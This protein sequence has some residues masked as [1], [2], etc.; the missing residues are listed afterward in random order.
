LIVSNT[1]KHKGVIWS[2]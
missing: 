1:N 2:N